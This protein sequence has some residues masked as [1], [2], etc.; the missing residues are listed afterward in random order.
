M[1]FLFVW[2]LFGFGINE[3]E[4]YEKESDKDYRLF[5]AFDVDGRGI[6]YVIQEGTLSAEQQ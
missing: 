5:A 6:L 1:P 4:E 3:N 2:A